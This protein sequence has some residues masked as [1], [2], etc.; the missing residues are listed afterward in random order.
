MDL[1]SAALNSVQKSLGHWTAEVQSARSNKGYHL[2]K[3]PIAQK[4]DNNQDIGICYGD[5]T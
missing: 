5:K 4:Y 1:L 2:K 3:N